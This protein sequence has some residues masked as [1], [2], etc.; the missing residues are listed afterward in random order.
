RGAFGFLAILPL[1][2]AALRRGQRNT[3]LVVLALA[4]F[5]VWGTEWSTG[6]FARST[7]NESFL[8]LL[9]FL[10]SISVP[11]LVLSADVAMRR[12]AEERISAALADQQMLLREVHHRVKNNLQMI[13]SMIH[14]R[15]RRVEED[16]RE[17]FDALSHRVIAMGKIYEQINQAEDLQDIDLG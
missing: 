17:H 6:P 12:Y 3:A 7:L 13:A 11:S 9:M 14:L 16:G 4:G 1:L 8:L 5:A 10:I 15:G 2:W